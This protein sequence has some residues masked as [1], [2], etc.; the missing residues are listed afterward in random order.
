MEMVRPQTKVTRLVDNLSISGN[1]A[2]KSNG[3]LPEAVGASVPWRKAGVKYGTNE[4]FFDLIEEIDATIDSNGMATSCDVQGS[5]QCNCH[6][7]GMPDCTMTFADP[8]ML[9]DLAFHPCVRFSR[10]QADQ[11]LSFIPPDGKCKLLSYCARDCG[12]NL[13]LYFKPTISFAG[14]S[15]HIDIMVG[16]K[17][18]LPKGAEDLLVIIPMDAGEGA[19]M[20]VGSLNTT[21]GKTHYDES[22]KELV[23]QIG[24]LPKDKSPCLSGS[25]TYHGG[26]PAPSPTLQARF[27][28]PMFSVSGVKV[29]GLSIINTVAKPYK[30]VRTIAKSGRFQVRTAPT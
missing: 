12:D 21:F 28:V 1:A 9:D 16:S 29:D 8:S 10:F 26:L 30:G 20:S 3:V 17:G 7:S 2:S 18:T 23:W 22:K 15:G 14:A 6:L 24:R 13:P 27:R 4:I 19:S 5:I 11:Q 25:L